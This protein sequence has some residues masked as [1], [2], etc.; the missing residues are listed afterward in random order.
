[1]TEPTTLAYAA[2]HRAS[3]ATTEA[4]QGWAASRA[5]LWVNDNVA[6]RASVDAVWP[7][8][9]AAGVAE[10]RRQAAADIRAEIIAAAPIPKWAQP[11][12]RPTA[13]GLREWAAT[14][15]EGTT[16][17]PCRDCL[18]DTTST[19]VEPSTDPDHPADQG[20][21]LASV[22]PC[23]HWWYRRVDRDDA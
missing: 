2:A 17:A 20:W 8:A 16:S 11:G 13:S 12:G 15:A 21:E 6:V 19:T 9:F 4:V 7:L 22:Q 14:I 18:D 23:G 3:V 10:G 5:E 1:M